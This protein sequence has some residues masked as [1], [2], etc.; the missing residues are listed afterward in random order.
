MYYNLKGLCKN[1]LVIASMRTIP[2]VT[3]WGQSASTHPCC[4]SIFSRERGT[5]VRVRIMCWWGVKKCETADAQCSQQAAANNQSWVSAQKND[6]APPACQHL[7]RLICGAWGSESPQESWEFFKLSYVWWIYYYFF[8]YIKKV[9]KKNI[10]CSS[11]HRRSADGQVWYS[12]CSSLILIWRLCGLHVF[13]P[14]HSV[15]SF[16]HARAPQPKHLELTG[17]LTDQQ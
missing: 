7:V 1:K 8:I 4:P 3:T 11:V 16:C 9:K 2:G 5:L 17:S 14:L 15:T 13:K 12:V 10:F 6:P